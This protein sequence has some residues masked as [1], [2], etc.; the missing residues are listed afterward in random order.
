[1]FRIYLPP[2]CVGAAS[3]RQSLQLANNNFHP[4]SSI[5]RYRLA[6]NGNNSGLKSSSRVKEK[7]KER[8][9]EICSIF[10]SS[11]DKKIE[12][13]EIECLQI[14]TLT[15]ENCQ[16]QSALK[17]FFLRIRDLFADGLSDSLG[18]SYIIFFQLLFCFLLSD[19]FFLDEFF[20]NL[21]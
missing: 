9:S 2:V 4:S 7:E 13:R 19:N 11:F 12:F 6:A 1:M 20:I 16:Q 15:N 21:F 14:Q 5:T 18:L 8:E 10:S 3:R 17:L